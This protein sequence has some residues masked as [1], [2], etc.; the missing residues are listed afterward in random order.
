MTTQH[1]RRKVFISHYGGDRNAVKKFLD[2]WGYS[3]RVF[4][5]KQLGAAIPTFSRPIAGD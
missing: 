4:I 5:P 2:K 1:V 3:E